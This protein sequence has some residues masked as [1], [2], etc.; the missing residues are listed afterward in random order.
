MIVWIMST[1]KAYYETL[2][3]EIE[4]GSLLSV[5]DLI[6]LIMLGA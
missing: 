5:G 6:T 1:I 3:F 2:V 4:V